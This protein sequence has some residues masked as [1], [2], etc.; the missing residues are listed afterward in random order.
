MA[1]VLGVS[2]FYHDAAAA[3]IE[4]GRIVAAAQE[5]RFSREKHD[6]RFP[7]EAIA[8][9]LGEAGITLADVAHVVFYDKPFLKF[10]RLLDTYIATAPRGFKSFRMAIPVWLREKLFLK[11]YLV[12]ELKRLD[13]DFAPDRLMFAEHHFSHAASAFYPSPRP[14]SRSGEANR[15]ISGKSCISR[16]LSVFCTRP[17]P[18]TP[19]FG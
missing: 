2:A 7:L 12:R 5:E 17:L 3:L 9:V 19:G 8:Y 13:G 14:P 4:D 18:I 16:T 11:D 6:A 10:E 15:S 1:Y